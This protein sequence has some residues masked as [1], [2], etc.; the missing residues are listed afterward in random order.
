ML[1]VRRLTLREIRLPLKEPFRISSGVVSD[2]R[3]LLV[4]LEEA[5]GASAW[6]ECVAFDVPNYSPDTVDTCWLAITEWI[7]PR[8]LGTPFGHPREL[9]P[10]L[11]RDFRGHL[12]A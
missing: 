8:V 4:E 7:A 6:S 12:M 1:R 5:D 2:R 10:A 9:F 3:I 11:E